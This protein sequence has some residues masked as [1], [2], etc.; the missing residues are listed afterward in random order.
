MTDYDISELRREIRSL[1]TA[2]SDLGGKVTSVNRQL[3]SIDR[4]LRGFWWDFSGWMAV[5]LPFAG[6]IA[7]IVKHL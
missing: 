7:A 1:G 2:V 4:T 6:I 5:C 3:D